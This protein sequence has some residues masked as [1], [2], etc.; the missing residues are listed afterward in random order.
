MKLKNL[1]RKSK[2]NNRHNIAV[3]ARNL[4]R[5]DEHDALRIKLAEMYLIGNGLE[6]GALHKPLNVPEGKVNIKYIDRLSTQDLKIQ[7]PDID[8]PFIEVDIID[9]GEK[10][11]KIKDSSEDFIIACHFYEHCADPIQTLKNLLRVLKPGGG[12]LLGVPD[13]R[14]TFDIERPITSH[15]HIVI[16]HEN[17]PQATRLKHFKEWVKLVD[18]ISDKKLAD[19]R[20]K[21]LL[22]MD[23]SIHYHV[24]DYNA[25]VDHLLQTRLYLNEAFEIEIVARNLSE[26]LIYLK[27]N[28]PKKT[29]R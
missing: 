25:L 2:K 4:E 23:Y 27:K 29:K 13:K 19:A 18:G 1:P 26:N 6:I 9:D 22:D 21:E 5:G 7:Y 8:E 11:T 17:G 12:L 28:S 10:L 3:R 14:F 15:S 16:D 24:W 20:L